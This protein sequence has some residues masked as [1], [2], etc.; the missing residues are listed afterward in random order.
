[1]S[2]LEL[3]KECLSVSFK[4]NNV[5]NLQEKSLPALKEFAE[6]FFKIGF[7]STSALGDLIFKT[8]LNTTKDEGF[9]ATADAAACRKAIDLEGEEESAVGSLCESVLSYAIS[10]TYSML[11]N[12]ALWS[13]IPDGDVEDS[14]SP[15]SF[16]TA[17]VFT[18]ERVKNL[19]TTL[20][21]KYLM[22]T[23][24]EITAW[25]TDSLAYFLDVKSESNVTKGNFL[26]E[27]ANRL[28][29]AIQLR[30]ED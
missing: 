29:A 4:A 21:M 30:Y 28:V 12:P 7:E 1:M 11:E 19:L 25:Q 8:Y 27:K 5:C 16:L 23:T 14:E 18:A 24:D 10:F 9:N 17:Q 3:L 13:D 2:Q 22:L 15:E 6:C 26:R 20:T